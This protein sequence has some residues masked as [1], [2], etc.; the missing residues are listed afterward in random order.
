MTKHR[1]PDDGAHPAHDAYKKTVQLHLQETDMRLSAENLQGR[2]V[3]SAD[4]QGIGSIRA[5]F[6]DATDWRVELISIEL[7][8]DIADQIGAARS[9]FHRGLVEL[10]VAVVQ[11]GGDAV[12]VA[13]VAV[14]VDALRAV[15]RTAARVAP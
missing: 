13:V 8:K 9:M 12:V 1:D 14:A 15:H 11:S 5:V 3:I 2:T 10:P 7:R 6:L 4:R